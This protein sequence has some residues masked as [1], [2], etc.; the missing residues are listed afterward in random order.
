MVPVPESLRAEV[1]SADAVCFTSSSTVTGFVSSLGVSAAPP[2]VVCIGPV[3][4]ETA[5]AAGLAVTAVASSHTIDGLVSTL[6]EV[7]GA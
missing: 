1:A 6:S 3:T 2:V 7:L 4:A 5:A